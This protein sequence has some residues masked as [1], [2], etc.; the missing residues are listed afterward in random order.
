[1]VHFFTLEIPVP[2]PADAGRSL[3]NSETQMSELP[4]GCQ[5]ATEDVFHDYILVLERALLELRCR[6]RYGDSV[7]ID[8]VH[9]LMDALHN[10]PRMLRKYGGWHVVENIDADLAR[11]DR[12]WINLDDP[13]HRPSLTEMLGHAKAG[14]LDVL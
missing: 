11:Y 5:R 2:Q 6:I 12:K 9:D 7:T 8:E 3:H 10:I 1:M 14:D 4:P 13:D